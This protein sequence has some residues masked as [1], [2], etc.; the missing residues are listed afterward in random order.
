M[1]EEAIV[2]PYR[3]GDEEEVVELLIRVFKGWPHFDLQCTPLDHW[4]WKHEDNPTKIKVAAVSESNGKIVGCFHGLYSRVKVGEKTL[5]N[6]QGTDLAVDKDYRG[7]GL[8]EKMRPIKDALAH[9]AKVNIGY[10]LSTNPIVKKRLREHNR[11]FPSPLRL[12]S[13][14]WD[15]DLHLKMTNSLEKITHRYGYLGLNA[16]NR[17]RNTFAQKKG[18]SRDLEINPIKTFDEGIDRF[19]REVSANY[20]FIIERDASYL[21]WRY[22]DK[23]GGDYVIRQATEGGVVLGYIV[24]RINRYEEGYPVGYVVDLL[25][26]SDRLDVA[27]ALLSDADGFFSEQGVNIVQAMVFK[28]HPYERLLK[29]YNFINSVTKYH[30]GYRIY[31]LGD[32]LEELE[33]APP[34]RLHFTWGDLDWI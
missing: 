33:T 11:P 25:T 12:M 4:R 30:L 26:L 2:R 22:C 19:W 16:V 8:Y 6:Q 27:H 34:G 21:N 7:M 24:L 28:G 32:E 23:R 9:D 1:N 20:S 15:I 14:I 3:N 31:S 5:L 13:K 10:A 17:L 18:I 29:E